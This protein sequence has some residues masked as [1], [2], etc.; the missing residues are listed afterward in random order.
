MRSAP[1]A[2]AAI[3]PAGLHKALECAEELVV[4]LVR[5]RPRYEPTHRMLLT[6]GLQPLQQVGRNRNVSLLLVLD[7]EVELR[8]RPDPERACREVDVVPGQVDSFLIAKPALQQNLEDQVKALVLDR[9]EEGPKFLRRVDLGYRFLIL[10]FG[11]RQRLH[12]QLAVPQER[13]DAGMTV[14]YC[15]GGAVPTA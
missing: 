9:T 7:L 15:S 3:Q 12:V 10:G 1:R 4:R 14:G 2:Q 5:S 8:L 13:S 11:W 6:V